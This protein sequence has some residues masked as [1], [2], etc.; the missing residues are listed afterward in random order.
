MKMYFL[1]NK[2]TLKFT[3]MASYAGGKDTNS[4]EEKKTIYQNLASICIFLQ[5]ICLSFIFPYYVF[6]QNNL[7]VHY[8]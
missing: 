1:T 6:F 4:I 3:T 2:E 8:S 5:Y 7:P